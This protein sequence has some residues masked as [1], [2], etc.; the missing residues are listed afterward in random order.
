MVCNQH[1]SLQFRNIIRQFD[2]NIFMSA[3]Y[4]LLMDTLQPI[5]IKYSPR[6][7]CKLYEH[8]AY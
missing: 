7:W 1:L 2:C 8:T 3:Y 4:Y 5:K 6:S